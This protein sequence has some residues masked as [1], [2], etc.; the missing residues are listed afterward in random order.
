M[1]PVVVWPRHVLSLHPRRKRSLWT[2]LTS[3]FLF[4]SVSTSWH[5]WEYHTTY[6]IFAFNAL[7]QTGIF[8]TTFCQGE[9]I[10]SE[11]V[12]TYPVDLPSPCITNLSLDVSIANLSVLGRISMFVNF[13][14]VR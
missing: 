11:L 5:T 7:L 8:N 9:F 6:Y 2:K 14:S 3:T 4:A 10:F 12:E 13:S 1:L